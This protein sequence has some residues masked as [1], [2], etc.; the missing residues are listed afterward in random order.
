MK[1]NNSGVKTFTST[2]SILIH[3]SVAKVWNALVDPTIA[4][5]YFMGAAV[6]TD[7]KVGSPI[8]FK[9]EFNRNQYQEKGVLLKVEPN[10]QLQYSHWSPFDGL[11]DVQENYR[12]W[13]FNLSKKDKGILLAVSEDSIPTEKQKNR[14]DEFWKG[15]LETLKKI[16]EK[17]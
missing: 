9:G 7:W 10:V 6:I 8:L 13:S 2:S 12:T 14:S 1:N 17:N 16:V 11:P 5:E 3:A 4:K 15:A